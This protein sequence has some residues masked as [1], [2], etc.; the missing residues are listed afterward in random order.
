MLGFPKL[1]F[2][3]TRIMMFQLS[4]F[5]CK[6]SEEFQEDPLLGTRVKEIVSAG[7]A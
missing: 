1:D 6:G 7:S 3:G 5:Y 4:G 2:K